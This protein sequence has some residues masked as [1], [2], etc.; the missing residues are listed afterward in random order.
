MFIALRLPSLWGR[1][2]GWGLKNEEQYKK[3]KNR[4]FKTGTDDY[5]PMQILW[6]IVSP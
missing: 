3:T 5:S 2:L 6:V 1:G 4:L